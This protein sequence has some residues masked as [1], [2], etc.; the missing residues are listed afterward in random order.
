VLVAL[1]PRQWTKNGLLFVALACSSLSVLV[2]LFVAVTA[3]WPAVMTSSVTP[4]AALV[5]SRDPALAAVPA[6]TAPDSSLASP[7]LGAMAPTDGA[8]AASVG[9]QDEPRP[10]A[11]AAPVASEMSTAAAAWPPLPKDL[12]AVWTASPV[13]A[14]ELLDSFLRRFPDH[15]VA[16]EKLY[17]ALIAYGDQ[18]FWSGSPG[19]AAAQYDRARTLLPDRREAEVALRAVRASPR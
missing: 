19:G 15:P 14:V 7:G 3:T 1:R 9:E 6:A 16:R 5:A 13:E 11:E 8:A 2:G 4:R 17:A 10:A 12:D 18:L